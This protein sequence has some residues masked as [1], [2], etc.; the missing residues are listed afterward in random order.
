MPLRPVP[1]TGGAADGRL[2]R[3]APARVCAFG[4]AP[5][6]GIG[7]PAAIDWSPFA[8]G[9]PAAPRTTVESVGLGFAATPLA[10]TAGMP[11]NVCDEL[12]IAI[13]LSAAFAAID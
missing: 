1:D 6:T 4:A 12:P 11:G 9:A 8:P 10:V 2:A 5:A 7:V 13:V 3:G